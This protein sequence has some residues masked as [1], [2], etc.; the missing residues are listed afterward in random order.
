V[1]VTSQVEGDRYQVLVEDNGPGIRPD[2]REKIFL[3]FSRGWAH[4]RA[5]TQGAGLGLA[6]SWQ[7]MRRLGGTLELM[8]DRGCGACFRVQLAVCGSQES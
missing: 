1:R 4:T 7:I 6:I 2:E 5:G 3:K 8:P